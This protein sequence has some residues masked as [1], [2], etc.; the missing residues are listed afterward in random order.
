LQRTL[1]QPY[2]MILTRAQKDDV[3]YFPVAPKPPTGPDRNRAMA[4]K[5][6]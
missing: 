1:Q 6:I 3:A 2:L 5:S 4:R